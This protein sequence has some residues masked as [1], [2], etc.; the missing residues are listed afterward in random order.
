MLPDAKYYDVWIIKANQVIREIPAATIVQW[1]E[2]RR[3]VVRDKIRPAGTADWFEVGQHPSLVNTLPQKEN[4]ETEILEPQF[5]NQKHQGVDDDIDMIPLIDVSL[6]LLV[7]FLMSTSSLG[8]GTSTKLP[9]A[10][11][12][13][14]QGIKDQA[15]IEVENNKAYTVGFAERKKDLTTKFE[16]QER[17]IVYLQDEIKKGQEFKEITVYAPGD[18]SAGTI[19][20]LITSIE[21]SFGKDE[22]SK[23]H[24]G[25]TGKK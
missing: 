4:P 9:I 10:E 14:V 3:L 25:V 15:W 21:K 2:E 16:S 24:L 7:Y 6:V 12:A 18:I 23:I 1:I 13:S 20:T 19:R 11:Y 17:L 5:S 22:I 8:S